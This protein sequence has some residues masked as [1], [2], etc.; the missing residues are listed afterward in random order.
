[1]SFVKE[2]FIFFRCDGPYLWLVM[3]SGTDAIAALSMDGVK[4]QNCTVSVTLRS[5]TWVESFME[6]LNLLFES[7]TTVNAQALNS[8]AA[9]NLN[10]DGMF[11]WQFVP[12]LSLIFRRRRRLGKCAQCG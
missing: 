11:L 4:I 8:L 5:E 3:G 10:I 7:E 6:H 12:G 2:L 1:M 9:L